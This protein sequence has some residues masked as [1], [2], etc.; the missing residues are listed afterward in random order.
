MLQLRR[1]RMRSPRSSTILLEN[2]AVHAPGSVVAIEAVETGTGLVDLVV[3]DGGPGVD[4]AL[5][6]RAFAKGVSAT[7]GPNNGLGLYSARKLARQAGG[8]LDLLPSEEGACF[9]L[10]LP[11]ATEASVIDLRVVGDE[12]DP[13]TIGPPNDKVLIID[14]HALGGRDPGRRAVRRRD[15][16]DDRRPRT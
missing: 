7:P 12:S 6:D 13:L 2:A 5:A 11:V 14:D 3:Q 9:R 15:L 4:P 1:D 8:E 16:G 10:L